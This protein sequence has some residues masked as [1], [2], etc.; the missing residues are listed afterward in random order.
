MVEQEIEEEL[1][2]VTST[3]TVPSTNVLR[4]RH[5]LKVIF[6]SA[7]FHA[8]GPMKVLIAMTLLYLLGSTW[9]VY[10]K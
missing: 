7:T 10:V 3:G 4:F 5:N 2:R 8:D 9:Y 6:D 1:V